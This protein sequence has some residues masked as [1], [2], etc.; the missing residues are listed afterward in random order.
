MITKEQYDEMCR[1]FV[2]AR[3]YDGRGEFHIYV[4]MNCHS[5]MIT[6]F[7]DKGVTPFTIKCR[8]CG[9]VSYHEKTVL[10][11]PVEMHSFL[12]VKYWVRPTYEQFVRLPLN[13]R[14]HVMNGG[15]LFEQ[16][17]TNG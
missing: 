17:L 4:C 7:K 15:L 14:E 8:D 10:E 12:G 13:L 3:M 6:A 2:S 5:S 9:N 16:E 1:E 11:V